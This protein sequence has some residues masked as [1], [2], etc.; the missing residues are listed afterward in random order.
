MAYYTYILSNKRNG[1]LYIGI[2]NDTLRRVK[3][4]KQNTKPCF[5]KKYHTFKL[6]Y[7]ETHDDIYTAITREK[8]LKNWKRI[9]KISLIEEYNP[10]WID[11]YKTLIVYG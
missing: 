6:V 8:Q 10:E 9:W 3:E 4:H 7:F 1:T 11:L 2:S 5:T